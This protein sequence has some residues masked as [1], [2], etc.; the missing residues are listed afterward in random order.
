MNGP[1]AATLP[2]FSTRYRADV[3]DSV[4]TTPGDSTQATTRSGK[5]ASVTVSDAVEDSCPAALAVMRATLAPSVTPSATV[6]TGKVISGAP[7]GI[8]TMAG[9]VAS[10]TLSEAN[11]TRRAVDV[12]VFLRTVPSRAGEAPS[13]AAEAPNVNV[14][15]G[16][17]SS[18]TVA[19]T[20]AATT[21]GRP[22]TDDLAS[23]SV[24]W[25]PSTQAS[26]TADTLNVAEA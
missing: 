21:A 13:R 9:T 23:I 4:S 1:V 22:A 20:G 17:S 2:R 15:I 19:V 26:F 24:A 6:A 3:I 16:P 7:A 10:A 12:E 5:S 18:V 25:L 14:S 8:S 11:A